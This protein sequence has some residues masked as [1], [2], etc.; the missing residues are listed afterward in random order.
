MVDD[1]A[2]FAEWRRGVT[3]AH[4]GGRDRFRQ[5]AINTWTN[6]DKGQKEVFL[7]GLN[8]WGEEYPKLNADSRAAERGRPPAANADSI[9][10]LQPKLWDDAPARD[11][12]GSA[13]WR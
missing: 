3:L 10:R 13:R 1:Y 2:P 11:P 9:H 6:G 7:S 5:M 4:A 12:G 8:W